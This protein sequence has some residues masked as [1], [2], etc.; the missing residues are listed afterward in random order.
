MAI[1]KGQPARYT[2]TLK[3]TL[4][5]LQK[6]TRGFESA[7][8]DAEYGAQSSHNVM[9]CATNGNM[10]MEGMKTAIEEIMESNARIEKLVGVIEQISE[11][12]AIIDE[13]VFQTKL[14]SFNAAVEAER[15]G[16]HGRGFAVV[17]QEIGNLAKMS[18]SAALD[19]SV[20]VKG[21]TNEAKKVAAENKSRVENG[22]K[23]VSE[24]ASV[25]TE[26]HKHAEEVSQRSLKL[27]N[28]LKDQTSNIK[29]VNTAMNSI[30][31]TINSR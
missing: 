2:D 11:K 23:M 15:A 4:G 29:T 19:I 3:N 10:S 13:I 18:G 9:E 12:T 17:A 26:I 27:V 28:E 24:I 8:E 31:E 20:I 14:L 16:E 22:S 7:T 5:S 30:Y 21:S 25:L 1:L 6:I